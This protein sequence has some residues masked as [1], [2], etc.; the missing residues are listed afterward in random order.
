MFDELY[1]LAKYKEYAQAVVSGRITACKLIIKACERYLSYFDRP[2]MYFEPTAV[3]RVVNFI[4][5][6][7][8]DTGEYNGK[9]FLLEPWQHWVICGIFGFHWKSTGLRVVRTFYLEVARKNGKSSLLSAIA[10]YMMI[11]DGE[12]N[13]SCVIAANS[14]KQAGL[15]FTMASHYLKSID[16]KGK[17]FQRFRDSIKFDKTSSSIK[18]VAADASRLDGLNCSFFVCD[19]MHEAPD[20]KVYDVLETSQG[21]RRQPLACATTTAGFNLTSFC[22]ELRKSNADVLY[23]LKT[24]DSVFAVIYTLDDDDDWKDEKVWIKA[25]PNLDV[26]VKKDF[27]R[28]QIVKAANNPTQE[29]SI[30]T[31]LCNQWLASHSVWIPMQY[32]LNSMK[33]VDLKDFN[34]LFSVLGVDLAAV[35]DLTA[36]SCHI[37]VDGIHY[38]KN[39]YFLPTDVLEN[40][41]NAEKYKR[42]ARQ[43]HLILTQGN[44]T[45]YDVVIEQ[46]K[47][48]NKDLLIEK[49]AYDQWNATSFAVSLTNEGFT[50]LPFAQSIAS[51]NRPTKELQ[52]LIMMGKVVIDDN[53][54]TAWCFEN[55]VAMEDANANVKIIKESNQQKI[56][57]CIAMINALGGHIIDET[58]DNVILSTT[59]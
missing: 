44:V 16:P 10:L 5:K 8:H 1:D 59:A 48:V 47:K 3:D 30:R 33:H 55:A 42:W 20:S 14:A 22:H 15:L 41:S 46:V 43:G 23:G 53:P 17:Y 54:I 6:L 57:G 13:A 36:L 32:V 49:I 21:S 24:D 40:N 4:S 28:Q 38:F 27:I 52:R 25:N 18:V 11:G 35:C 39:Y 34:G 56:D 45:D 31:K 7:K 12:A 19:E 58:W 9:P 37:E 26:S 2:D 50:M 29:L 51:M